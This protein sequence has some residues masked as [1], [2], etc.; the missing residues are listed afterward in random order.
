MKKN[1]FLSVIEKWLH[2]DNDYS[3]QYIIDLLKLNDLGTYRKYLKSPREN[4]TIADMEKLAF[5]LDKNIVEIFW[6]CYKRPYAEII[7]DEEQVKLN[8]S[9]DRA[10]IR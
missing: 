3:N 2:K 6:A 4:F 10:G 1:E 7:H 5:L 8:Q 9:L